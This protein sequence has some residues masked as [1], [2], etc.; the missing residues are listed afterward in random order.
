[1]KRLFFGLIAI[2]LVSVAQV[3]FVHASTSDFVISDFKADYYLDRGD[4]GQST[5]KTVESITAEFPN[6]DQNHGIERSLPLSYDGHI[7]GLKIQSV[8][9]QIGDKLQ[10]STSWQNN[11][12]VLRIGDADTFVYGSQTY[13]ITYTQRN[14]TRFF[15]DTNSDEFYWD[16]NGTGW[17]QTFNN[18]TAR[19]HIGSGVANSLNGNQA[20][21]SGVSGSTDK[22]SI[23]RMGDVFIANTANLSAGGNMTVAIGFKP[24]TFSHYKLT[25]GDFVE[26]YV[27]F[28]SLAFSIILIAIMLLLKKLKG[29]GA[30][31]RGIIIAEYLPPKDA[32]V[33][34]S[35][36]IARRSITWSS[37]TYIDLA[38]RHKLKIIE[39]DAGNNSKST[40]ILEFMTSDGL[41]DAENGVVKALFGDNPSAGAQY[42]IR[43]NNNNYLFASKISNVYRQSR[44]L[45]KDR[46][47]YGTNNKLKFIMYLMAFA[48]FV[49]SVVFEIMYN[50]GTVYAGMIMAMFAVFIPFTIK[51][52]S[53]SGRELFDYLKGL[54]LYIKIAEE[55]RIKVLQSPKGADK[56]PIDV[57]DTKKL[58]H[59]YERVLPYAVLFGN[60]KEWT[61]VLGKYYEQQ[62]IT[63]DWYYGNVAFDAIMFSSALSNFS[64][65]AMSNSSYSSSTG[66]SG[67]GGFSGGGGGG[68][69]GGG[70]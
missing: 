60:E 51:P 62:N 69:G 39:K 23:E 4:K 9:N 48:I 38:V 66:G 67:G 70:W 63:P 8:T 36:V 27:I 29:M 49:Q 10:Y 45:A 7:T 44:K 20:C 35:S 55:D 18:V 61:K 24:K 30:P 5:L 2:V 6:F 15:S 16:I 33:A 19:L 28:I 40:Y 12:L 54:E 3:N 46:G 43:L 52:L 1:M 53:K 41:T 65:S 22:C 13:V 57:N 59:L 56:T 42:E 50:S 64:Q 31:G 17:S 26:Q 58:V 21:Y 14:V 25:L 11:N 47:Y 37:A 32:D 68:G 34:L